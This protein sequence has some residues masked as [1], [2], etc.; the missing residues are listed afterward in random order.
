MLG[1]EVVYK[2]IGAKR[3]RVEEQEKMVYIPLLDTLEAVLQNKHVV[4]EV[5]VCVYMCTFLR[6]CLYYVYSFYVYVH[7][8]VCYHVTCACVHA[9][10]CTL[11]FCV[12]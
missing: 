4:S 6:L 3:R 2:G 10:T 1:I 7:L 8:H 9:Y 12:D 11:I 5:H